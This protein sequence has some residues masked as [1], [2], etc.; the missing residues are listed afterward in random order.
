MTAPATPSLEELV[1]SLPVPDD[2]QLSP[3]GRWVI[4]SATPPGKTGDF[5]EGALWIAPVDGE[6]EPRRFTG[7]TGRDYHPR[8]SP[9]GASIAFLSD[10]HKPGTFALWLIARRGGEARLL[11][12]RGRSVDAFWWSPDGARIAF[13][14]PDE[15]TSE[16]E[17]RARERD[18]AEVYGERWP[19]NRLQVVEL[20]TG[21]VSTLPTGDVHVVEAAWSHGGDRLAVITAPTPELETRGSGAVSVVPLDGSASTPVCGA[22]GF[23]IGQLQ[24]SEDGRDLLFVSGLD[25]EPQ[26][27]ST[28]YAVSANGGTPRVVGPTVNDLE[29]ASRLACTPDGVAVLSVARGL[30]TDLRLLDPASGEQEPLFTPGRGDIEGYSV[31]GTRNSRV[32]ALIKSSGSE[33][34]EVWA[35][36]P[37]NLRR[38]SDHHAPLRA[39]RFGTQEEFH[40]RAADGLSLD[41]VL[42]RPP[43]APAGPL[44]TVVLVHGGP[45]SRTTAGWNLRPQNWGQWLA[46]HGYLVLMPNYRGGTGHGHRFAV[47]ARGAVGLGDFG[48]VMS[49]VD[50]AVERGLADPDR[51]GIGGWSQGGFMTAWAVTQTDRFKAAVMGAGVTDW[52]MMTMTSD[53]PTFESVLGGSRPWDG[54]GPHQHARISPISFAARAT[55]PTLILHGRGDPR[56]PVSQAIGFERALREAGAPVRLVVYPREP[57]R[58]GERAHQLDLMRRVRDWYDRWLGGV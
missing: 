52:G 55:T 39:F 21:T 57:H 6:V 13:L 36:P 14:A 56:V 30:T 49:G 23:G 2:P 22:P 51:L 19:L 42:I 58:I 1:V 5:P 40:W 46:A 33:P 48:D 44:A 26:G 32:L 3:D 11:V 12:E 7:G 35:G 53:L 27:S 34:P 37:G 10:R 43:D 9:D 15:P 29:C 8:W 31:G 4:W 18:D 25:R 17:R 50:A 16:D 24:W 28:V 54:V 20:A 47:T 41:G 38:L 45:Y